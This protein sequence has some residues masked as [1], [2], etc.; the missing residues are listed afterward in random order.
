M[1]S[2]DDLAERLTQYQTPEQIQLVKNGKTSMITV[3]I[4]ATPVYMADFAG[5]TLPSPSERWERY[6]DEAIENAAEMPVNILKIF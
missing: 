2:I 4:Y 6:S 1:P 5:E 3:K